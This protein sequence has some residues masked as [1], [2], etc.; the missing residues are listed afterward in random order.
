MAY[1]TSQ[2]DNSN[3]KYK[4]QKKNEKLKEYLMDLTDLEQEVNVRKLN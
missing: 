4:I 2:S 1:E 3:L